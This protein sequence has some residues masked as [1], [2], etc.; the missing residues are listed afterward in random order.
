M[1]N[2]HRRKS[3]RRLASRRRAV[4]VIFLLAVMGGCGAK[5]DSQ[6]EYYQD[7]LECF[8]YRPYDPNVTREVYRRGIQSGRAVAA[9]ID[10]AKKW[11]GQLQ[12]AARAA[13]REIVA[14][15]KEQRHVEG[16]G[17]AIIMTEDGIPELEQ[18]RAYNLQVARK[19]GVLDKIEQEI[20]PDDQKTRLQEAHLD[21]LRR[22]LAHLTEHIDFPYDYDELQEVYRVSIPLGVAALEPLEG[23][24]D[25]LDKYLKDVQK[26]TAKL[27]MLEGR[28]APRVQAY[29][30]RAIQIA[31]RQDDIAEILGPVVD[32]A[33]WAR[34]NDDRTKIYEPERKWEAIALPGIN[35]QAD[36]P[37]QSGTRR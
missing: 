6:Q 18:Y 20:S 15:H 7:L 2:R 3:L 33:A 8:V 34:G 29:R 16:V 19:L 28:N 37:P 14:S 31:Q 36:L 4:A 23:A 24:R 10:E 22:H 11:L 17:P 5:E 12:E 32:E 9:E 21:T 25:D 13:E 35:P 27:A 30:L 26:L 1:N